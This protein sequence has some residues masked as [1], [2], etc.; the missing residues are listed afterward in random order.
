[1]GQGHPKTND[2]LWT[3][4]A[5]IS[6]PS[7]FTLASPCHGLHSFGTLPTPLC[8]LYY[9]LYLALTDRHAAAP[10]LPANNQPPPGP[11]HHSPAPPS[12]HPCVLCMDGMDVAA[13]CAFALRGMPLPPAP[14]PHARVPPTTCLPEHC[15]AFLF[16]PHTF[17]PRHHALNLHAAPPPFSSTTPLP[18][19]VALY[20]PPS[21][22]Y[23][24]F[25]TLACHIHL[26]TPF[27]HYIACTITA[28]SASYTH[29][30][31]CAWFR[32]E[33]CHS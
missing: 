3:S 22:T 5:D 4:R 33:R 6:W 2:R 17:L 10:T 16:S 24:K 9:I 30:P 25:C 15:G 27:Y 31:L 18:C 20:L 21:T 7:T 1:M 11:W 23:I 28:P 8:L 12:N 13:F 19:L 29:T 14:P 32:T 26:P